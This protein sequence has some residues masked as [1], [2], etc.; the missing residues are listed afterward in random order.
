MFVLSILLPK[1]SFSTRMDNT[2]KTD[3][4]F[5]SDT[6]ETDT[7]CM[8]IFLD[9][10]LTSVDSHPITFAGNPCH[11]M[12]LVEKWFFSEELCQAAE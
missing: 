2:C 8:T 3:N 6:C 7:I 12:P 4:I 9:L 10:G 1:D 11:S 5:M